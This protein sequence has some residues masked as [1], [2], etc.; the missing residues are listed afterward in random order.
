[1]PQRDEKIEAIKW[2]S[3][4]VEKW[5]GGKVGEWNGGKVE[6]L[7]TTPSLHHAPFA[8]GRDAPPRHVSVS[9]SLCVKN[10]LLRQ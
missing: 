2:K 4:K 7:D 9:L 1:M 10:L 8:A 6:R 3:G 5:N